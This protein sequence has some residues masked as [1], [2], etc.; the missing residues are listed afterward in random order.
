M[1]LAIAR[2]S[3]KK[4]SLSATADVGV[5]FHGEPMPIFLKL[6]IPLLAG[7]FVTS[8][9]TV[10]FRVHL[11]ELGCDPKFK[12]LC[13]LSC[14]FQPIVICT[15]IF[16]FAFSLAYLLIGKGYLHKSYKYQIYVLT[17]TGSLLGLLVFGQPLAT[18]II[19]YGGYFIV[20]FPISFVFSLIALM[21]AKKY[22]K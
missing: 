16:G 5:I 14:L 15:F 10:G 3:H 7:F 19:I 1:L 18:I 21:L 17:I 20:W 4:P 12:C 2:L 8:F 6:M 13:S 22:N 11:L 9:I